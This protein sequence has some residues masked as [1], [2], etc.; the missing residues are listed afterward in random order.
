MGGSPSCFLSGSQHPWHPL[1]TISHVVHSVHHTLPLHSMLNAGVA[2]ASSTSCQYVLNRVLALWWRLAVLRHTA[3]CK[4]SKR[5]LLQPCS[6]CKPLPLCC[7]SSK[8]LGG[9]QCTQTPCAGFYRNAYQGRHPAATARTGAHVNKSHQCRAAHVR[10]AHCR[11]GVPVH[12]TS[13]HHSKAGRGTLLQYPILQGAGAAGIVAVTTVQAA[14]HAVAAA[15]AGRPTS[16]SRSSKTTTQKGWQQAYQ[17]QHKQQQPAGEDMKA[18][19]ALCGFGV[20]CELRHRAAAAS[21]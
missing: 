1:P 2:S 10:H 17:Q 20:Q 14:C 7:T 8:A 21:T 6:A 3:S 15:A 5:L 18:R 9:E 13:C 19:H 4:C 16:S 11:L 12:V